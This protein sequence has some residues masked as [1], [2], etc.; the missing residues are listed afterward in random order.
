MVRNR[1]DYGVSVVLLALVLLVASATAMPSAEGASSPGDV[2]EFIVTL[3]SRGP[4]AHAALA[5]VLRQFTVRDHLPTFNSYLVRA[6]SNR[7]ASD[8]VA[9]LRGLPGVLAVEPNVARTIAEPAPPSPTGSADPQVDRQWHLALIGESLVPASRQPAPT[10]A[11]LDTG[12][13]YTNPDLGS[14]VVNANA[15]PTNNFVSMTNDP[16]DDNGHG[17]HVAGVVAAEAG[18]GRFGRGVSPMSK[19]LA[20]KVLDEGGQ[21]TCWNVARGIEYAISY[22]PDPKSVPPVRAINLSLGD[23]RGCLAEQLAVRRARDAGVLVVGA[24]GNGNSGRPFYPGA[25]PEAIA[26][27]ATEHHDCRATFSNYGVADNPWVDVAAPGTA[28]LS[29]S[30]SGGMSRLDGTSAAAP[31]VA[32]I[33]ARAWAAQP[34][35]GLDALRRLVVRG[36]PRVACGFPEGTSL[37]RADLA[38]ALGARSG[39]FTGVA[40]SATTGLP[41][42]GVAARLLDSSGRSIASARTNGSG[43]YLFDGLERGRYRLVLTKPGYATLRRAVLVP[44]PRPVEEAL[45]PAR[46]AGE[47]TITLRWRSSQP[48]SGAGSN[49]AASSAELDAVLRHPDASIG[50][51]SP[52]NPGSLTPPAD[53]RAMRD[54]LADLDPVEA[55]V[56]SRLHEGIYRFGVLRPPRTP[57][58][59]GWGRLGG[60]GA[61]VRVYAGR[62][63]IRTFAVPEDCADRNWWYVFDLEGSTLRPR[64][65]CAYDAPPRLDPPF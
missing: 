12:V 21:G 44:N 35:L 5:M 37:R 32:G 26:V 64:G 40:R 36:G 14:R 6:R 39:G 30:L 4:E 9:G 2:S 10:V 46:G 48:F 13:D 18:N 63:L 65:V 61:V 8:A 11:I 50:Y 42:D 53:A 49:A 24:A 55:I 20:V 25:Y 54:S 52:S 16:M 45:A 58:T 17:T 28:I 3:D 29:L 38:D 47:W 56:I 1:G 57:D 62:R 7:I 23:Y 34:A 51:L 43:F 59:S 27:A 41:I 15:G 60:S 33:A 22:R 31:I 19:V